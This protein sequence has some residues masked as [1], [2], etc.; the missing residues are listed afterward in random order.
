MIAPAA[1][2]K[3]WPGNRSSATMSPK[4]GE[5]MADNEFIT[6]PYHLAVR[7]HV[8]YAADIYYKGLIS[9]PGIICYPLSAIFVAGLVTAPAIMKGDF[10]ATVLLAAGFIAIW[11]IVIP[12]ISLWQIWKSI[13]GS[14]ATTGFRTL[15][16]DDKGVHVRG[17]EFETHLTWQSFK[18]VVETKSYVALM[19]SN[20][21]HIVPN[22][23]FY[24]PADAKLFAE[25][26]R[27]H[28][29]NTKNSQ[30]AAFYDDQPVIHKPSHPDAKSLQSPSFIIDLRTFASLVF[31]IN[32]H[33]LY[34]TIAATC[35]FIIWIAVFGWLYRYDLMDGYWND[36]IRSASIPAIIY[37]L[38]PVM[39]ILLGWRK[40]HNSPLV[41]N[42]RYVAISPD[43]IHTT[44]YGYDVRFAWRD[45]K[46][47]ERFGSVTLF[48]T[49]PRGAIPLPDSA[50]PDKSAA[51]AFYDQALAYFNAAKTAAA[52]SALDG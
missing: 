15:Q 4:L 1:M 13:K 39:S 44:G 11:L 8:T 30:T 14:P 40:T 31:R 45:L 32:F 43:A 37:L 50:F 22:S 42:D 2:P 7:D 9:L 28:L 18:K 48:Y 29:A 46:R 35:L 25:H 10:A 20:E 26:A 27:S 16:A 6:K 52:K 3:V 19:R 47:M 33:L 21:A 36:A 12:G 5:C 23:A 41:K 17:E 24:T 34:N 51:K 38:L 49:L